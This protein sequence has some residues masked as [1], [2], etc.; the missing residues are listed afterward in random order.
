M[1][2]YLDNGVTGTGGRKHFRSSEILWPTIAL[3]S[4]ITIY[5]NHNLNSQVVHYYPT[6]KLSSSGAI[7]V[8]TD[9]FGNDHTI[10]RRYGFS[11]SPSTANTLT[12]SLR[13][14]IYGAGSFVLD[15]FAEET[16]PDD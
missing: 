7:Y 3:N 15:I 6:L 2:V 13:T 4:A 5:I 10:V 9:Y 16:F 12:L 1:K 11:Q 14:S 8:P